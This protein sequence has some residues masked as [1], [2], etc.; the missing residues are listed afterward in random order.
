MKGWNVKKKYVHGAA[1][2]FPF[3]DLPSSDFT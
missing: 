1:Y 2:N 3:K